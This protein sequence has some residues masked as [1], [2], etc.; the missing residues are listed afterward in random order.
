MNSKLFRR[1]ILI[2]ESEYTRMRVAA[3]PPLP[4]QDANQTDDEQ[5]KIYANKLINERRMERSNDPSMLKTVVGS[6]PSESDKE[7]L[8][9]HFI[10]VAI[11]KFARQRQQRGR[12]IFDDI[13]NNDRISWD[14][15]GEVSIDGNVI[16]SS[17]I[18]DLIHFATNSPREM[19]KKSAPIGWE[20]FS[21]LLTPHPPQRQRRKRPAE[22]TEDS[23]D[24]DSGD[25]FN[26][27]L[28]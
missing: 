20:L 19:N 10:R 17:Y 13:S 26:A 12:K 23:D 9:P 5:Q 3:P 24:N 22:I 21:T 6:A 7:P 15:E 14:R 28:D 25:E 18:L 27:F 16:P 4:T 1:M 2:P 8:S 11:E